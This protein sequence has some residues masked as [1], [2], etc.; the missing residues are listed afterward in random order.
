MEEEEEEARG[1]KLAISQRGWE[2]AREGG[3]KRDG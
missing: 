1:G 3:I 2:E